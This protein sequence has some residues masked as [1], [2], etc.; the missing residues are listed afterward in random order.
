M[1]LQRNVIDMF[2][3]L[4][5]NNLLWALA[6]RTWRP[7]PR[8]SMDKHFPLRYTNFLIS[9]ASLLHPCTR[10]QTYRSILRL[11]LLLTFVSS[12]PP[13]DGKHPRPKDKDKERESERRKRLWEEDKAR[14]DWERQKRREQA[15]AHSRRER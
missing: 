14:R 11:V 9:Y 12:S 15:R 1:L 6:N 2:F 8:G 13:P 4:I 5:N 3:R 7:L 10:V